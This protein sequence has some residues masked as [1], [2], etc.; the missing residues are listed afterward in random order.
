[1]SSEERLIGRPLAFRSG[2]QEAL[3]SG[4]LTTR[5]DYR[6]KHAIHLAIAGELKK[7][8]EPPQEMSPKLARLLAQLKENNSTIGKSKAL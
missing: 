6:R 8:Y 4:R 1:M 7:L 5:T 3:G 2:N